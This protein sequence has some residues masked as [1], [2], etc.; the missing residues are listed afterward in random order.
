MKNKKNNSKEG[1]FIYKQSIY[2]KEEIIKTK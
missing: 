1:V 2:N